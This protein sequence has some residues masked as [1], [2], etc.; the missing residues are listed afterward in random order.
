MQVL[1][2]SVEKDRSPETGFGVAAVQVQS[3]QRKVLLHCMSSGTE[4]EQNLG[5][6]AEPDV[7]ELPCEPVRQATFCMVDVQ[8]GRRGTRDAIDDAG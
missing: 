7:T 3:K 1:R 4:M 6:V 2:K 5:V 8:G